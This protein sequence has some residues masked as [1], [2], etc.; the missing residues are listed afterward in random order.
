MLF[1]LTQNSLPAPET[2]VSV[3]VAVEQAIDPYEGTNRQLYR[4]NEGLDRAVLRPIAMTYRRVLPRPIRSGV[5]NAISNWDEPV[6]LVNDLLQIRLGDAAHTTMR[7]AINTTFGLAGLFD[8]ASGAG[9][10]HHD[11][12]FG[13][14]LGR[15]GV[16]SGPY[17]YLPFIGPSSPR[18]LIGQG[19]DFVSN[20]LTAVS[21]IR[22]RVLEAAQTVVGVLDERVGI[23]SELK[24][25]NDEATDPYAYV[26]SIYVQHVEAQIAGDS[27]FLD[28]IPDIPALQPAPQAPTP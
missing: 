11:N 23:E 8:V 26:R 19:I 13:I 7:F 27:A 21:H 5:H 16:K 9:L 4:L 17:L 10:P 20:P 14:T 15:Y 1:D 12:G 25:V 24:S 18:A 28:P 3:L 2:A 6:V 22:S